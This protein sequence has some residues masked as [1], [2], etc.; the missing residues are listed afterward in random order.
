MS[1]RALRSFRLVVFLG[2]FALAGFYA[3]QLFFSPDEPGPI[4]PQ[5]L[6][7]A[8]TTARAPGADDVVADLPETLPD[9][10]LEMLDG[11]I[12]SI[13]D[14]S[15]GPLLINF[16]ATWCAP[17]LREM[18]ML[19]SVW[20]SRRDEGLTIVGIAVDRRDAVETYLEQTPVTYP[21][22]I[23]R[24]DAMEAADAFGPDF[25]GL[26][27]T[28]FVA[29]GG[30]VLGTSSGE[31]HLPDLQPLLDTVFAASAGT[32][33]VAEARQRFTE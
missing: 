7:G 3:G 29:A 15:D 2:I 21:V 4:T 10:R 18:P 9:I 6:T 8:E 33:P 1:R 20:Q 16:W 13:R 26:P 14:W 17:C 22:L 32:L 23:G 31:L 30:R 5:M 27:Y 25:A 12:R 19:E 28:I 11:E 24:S